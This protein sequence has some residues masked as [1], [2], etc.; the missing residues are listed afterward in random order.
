[1]KSQQIGNIN[2]EE[3]VF[4]KNQMTIL[5]SKYTIIKM[6]NSLIVSAVELIW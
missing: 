3:N 6:E 4:L 5:Q 2:K 1:M